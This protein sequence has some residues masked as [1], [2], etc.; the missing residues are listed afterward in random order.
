MLTYEKDMG[1]PLTQALH[2]HRHSTHT[3]TSLTQAL[4]SHRHSTHTG[5]PLTQA[6]HSWSLLICRDSLFYGGNTHIHKVT[7]A[8]YTGV[9]SWS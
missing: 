6:L 9:V 2:S 1:T 7:F 5:T 3:G 8:Q 4:H